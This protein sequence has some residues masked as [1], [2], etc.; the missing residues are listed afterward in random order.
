MPTTLKPTAELTLPD[1]WERVQTWKPLALIP[2]RHSPT[3]MLSVVERATILVHIVED[4]DF[5]V[6]HSMLGEAALRLAIFQRRGTLPYA[7]GQFLAESL[8]RVFGNAHPRALRR[9][10]EGW[11]I[12]YALDGAE[13]GVEVYTSA[14]PLPGSRHHR[15]MRLRDRCLELAFERELL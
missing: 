1:F 7:S 9:A 15:Q 13:L 4:A 6:E 8:Q 5:F 14:E 3:R 2:A 12:L 10:H 11:E